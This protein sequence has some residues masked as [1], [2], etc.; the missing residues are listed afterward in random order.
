MTVWCQV[1][2]PFNRSIMTYYNNALVIVFHVVSNVIG[3]RT[4]NFI[5]MYGK[6]RFFVLRPVM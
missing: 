2:A 1:L 3:I 5:T 4:N 6:K